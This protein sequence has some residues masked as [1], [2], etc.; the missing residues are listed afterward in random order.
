VC[1]QNIE[2]STFVVF[3]SPQR[4][5]SFNLELTLNNIP[6]Q[7]EEC[8]KYLGILID[9]TFIMLNTYPTTLQPL[10]YFKVHLSRKI[11]TT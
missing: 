5:L 7:Q 6:L 8:I 4:K 11:M 2:K 10:Y 3:H 1:S 9:S